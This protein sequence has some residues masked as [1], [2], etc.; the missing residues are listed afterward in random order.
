MAREGVTLSIE[1]I[2]L[3]MMSLAGS[4][5]RHESQARSL[6]AGS[7]FAAEHDELAT[8]MRTLR[9]RLMKVRIG[10]SP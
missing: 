10:G 8:R 5:S 1:E 6:K 9:I 7:A 2:D 4:A 3:M